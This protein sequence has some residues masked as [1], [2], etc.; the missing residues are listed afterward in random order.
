[1]RLCNLF[2][3]LVFLPWRLETCWAQPG[4]TPIPYLEIQ[5]KLVRQAM[6][7]GAT[8]RFYGEARPDKKTKLLVHL[9]TRPKVPDDR[10]N[11]LVSLDIFSQRGRQIQRLSHL[12]WVQ[13]VDLR[14]FGMS[15]LWIDPKTRKIPALLIRNS[16]PE[17]FNGPFG[18]DFLMV[19]APGWRSV[20]FKTDS[21]WG[22]NNSASD[23]CRYD[24]RD[25]RGYMILTYDH[26]EG[27]TGE[28]TYMRLYW[29]GKSFSERPQP[30]ATPTAGSE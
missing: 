1:M 15:L 10:E 26:N 21:E 7:R 11:Y 5:P 27:A 14:R 12:N 17:G 24:E 23:Y 13:E 2:I 8:S 6:P 3:L 19:F 9:Y 18:L 22:G 25:E 4:G 20:L 29:D 28:H 16:E 30:T